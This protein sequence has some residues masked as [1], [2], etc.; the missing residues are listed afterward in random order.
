MSNAYPSLE[1]AG[2]ALVSAAGRKLA[3]IAAFA[4][5]YSNTPEDVGA[6]VDVPVIGTEAGEFN[7]S[8]NNYGSQTGNFAVAKINV[9]KH[10]LAGFT[11]KP[12]QIENGLGAFNDL[13]TRLGSD[14]GRAVAK[15]VESDVFSLLSSTTIELSAATPTT[16]AGFIGLYEKT[17][18]MDLD[19]EDCVLVLNPATY[20]KCL[21]VINGD[22][23]NLEKAIQTGY[24][25]NFLGFKRIV[26]TKSLP[27][28]VNGAIIGPSGIGIAARNIDLDASAYKSLQTFQDVD[29]G[30]P[31]TLLTYTDPATGNVKISATAIWGQNIIVPEQITLLK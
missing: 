19:S 9:D 26:S 18:D 21:E 10:I 11:V 15:K 8:S 3:P 31:I 12:S 2:N 20:A 27:T 24:I 17:A 5:D 29:S 13:F 30:V 22:I 7:E 14:A 28:G 6:I 4:H 1:I 23:S 25:D 16:K